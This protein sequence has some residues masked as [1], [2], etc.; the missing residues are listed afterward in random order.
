[1]GYL[2][3]AAVLALVGGWGIGRWRALWLAIIVPI[4]AV[5][6]R[7]QYEADHG[8][9]QETWTES[10]A[11]FTVGALICL[12]LGVGVRRMFGPRRLWRRR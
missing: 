11:I 4:V 3:A 10:T 1:M 7:L 6:S 5:I 8:Q 9:P 12:T 2:F